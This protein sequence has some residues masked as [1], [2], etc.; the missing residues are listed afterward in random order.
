MTNPTGAY[1]MLQSAWVK[2]YGD[3]IGSDGQWEPIRQ[4]R[5]HALQVNSRDALVD[6]W[7]RDGRVFIAG[8]PDIEQ[9]E[10]MSAAS[11]TVD[12]TDPAL[13][14]T[15]PGGL[16]VVPIMVEASVLTVIAKRDLFVVAVGDTDTYT[17][18]GDTT[19]MTARNALITTGGTN[20]RASGVTNLHYSDTALVEGDVTNPMLLKTLVR[21][22]QASEV[23]TTWNPSYNILN[24]DKMVYIR[25]PASFLVWIAQETTAAEAMFHM[26]WAEFG[27]ADEVNS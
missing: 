25:G 23:N 22:G 3:G 8:N 10:T 15:I 16:V 19:T 20:V 9:F 6:Q 1:S 26:M 13:R 12:E 17:S 7:T 5:G 24:G 14:F 21:T 11:T 2:Q 27:D 18:G 4:N